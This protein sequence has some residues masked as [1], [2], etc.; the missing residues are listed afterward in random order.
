MLSKKT[1]AVKFE[2]QIFWARERFIELWSRN[3]APASKGLAV[4][5]A[6]MAMAAARRNM[7]VVKRMVA[8][9]AN[10]LAKDFLAYRMAAAAGDLDAMRLIEAIAFPTEYAF[11]DALD[12]ARANDRGEAVNHIKSLLSPVA[13]VG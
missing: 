2:I 5:D 1:T 12:W 9:G 11:N 10:P 3:V 4:L 8:L 13:G 6:T 7:P